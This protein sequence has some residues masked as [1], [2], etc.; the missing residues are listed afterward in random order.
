MLNKEIQ[1]FNSLQTE[2]QVKNPSG[3][4]AVICEEKLLGIW[5]ERNTAIEAGLTKYGNISFLVKSIFEQARTINFTQKLS[6]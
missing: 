1:Y 2:L 6:S 3:G 5:K 4:F